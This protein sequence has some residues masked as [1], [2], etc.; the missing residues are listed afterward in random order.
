MLM[1]L[2]IEGSTGRLVARISGY[3][4]YVDT[5]KEISTFYHDNSCTSVAFANNINEHEVLSILLS[6]A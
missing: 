3:N 6:I 5:Y 2:Y 4:F 1:Y